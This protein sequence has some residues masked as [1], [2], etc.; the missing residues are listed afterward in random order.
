MAETSM[1]IIE[2][3]AYFWVGENQWPE[4]GNWLVAHS[5]E[6]LTRTSVHDLKKQL[7]ESRISVFFDRTR[8]SEQY[9][10][11]I[12][13]PFEEYIPEIVLSCQIM[14]VLWNMKD[15]LLEFRLGSSVLDSCS[16]EQR[17]R[18]ELAFTPYLRE[19]LKQSLSIHLEYLATVQSRVDNQLLAI[20]DNAEVSR[21]LSDHPEIHSSITDVYWSHGA[22]PAVF[23]ST[24]QT[25]NQSEHILICANTDVLG[26]LMR[27]VEHLIW[28]EGF[29]RIVAAEIDAVEPEV[30]KVLGLSDD[31]RKIAAERLTVKSLLSSLFAPSRDLSPELGES[32]L[33]LEAA[34]RR[35]ENSWASLRQVRMLYEEDFFWYGD[36]LVLLRSGVARGRLIGILETD[37]NKLTLGGYTRR[38]GL[39]VIDFYEL[40]ID[41][42][43][44]RLRRLSESFRTLLDV[45]ATQ[46]S[47]L[48]NRLVLML[49]IV[50]AFLA[51]LQVASVYAVGQKIIPA[52]I[53]V[54]VLLLGGLILFNRLKQRSIQ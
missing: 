23:L 19:L 35:L 15:F 29:R 5:T 33:S 41:E 3:R 11:T 12:K 48:L 54:A 21:Y 42:A 44:E 27:E 18:L 16:A 43:R 4:L 45:R 39:Q 9:L 6:T 53:A 30:Q 8:L 37:T 13:L 1:K 40:R 50:S 34:A 24:P 22:N 17:E 28:H 31:F 52:V 51:A 47:D 25:L 2:L 49:T 36:K 10:G 20:T 46:Q 26:H 38:S 14:A 32:L 7:G